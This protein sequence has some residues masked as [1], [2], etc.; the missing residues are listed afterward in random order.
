MNTT[1]TFSRCLT[2][3]ETQLGPQAPKPRSTHAPTV[4]LSRMTG[5]GGTAVAD[6]LAD[7]LQTRRPG[8]PA[9]WTVFHRSLIEKVI[10]DHH[11][12]KDFSR[13]MP[14]NRV[15]YIQ[16]TLEEL[17]GLH[18]SASALVTQIAETILGLAELG[19][20][21]LVGRGAHLVLAKCPSAL[22]VRLVGSLD[23]RTQRVATA[24]SIPADEAR[25]FIK[26]EDAARRRYLR[27][28]F[29]ADIDDPVG[30][31]L[32]VNTD[33]LSAHAVADLIA[34]AVVLRFPE[35]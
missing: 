1:A 21:I 26:T 12:P 16:D 28:H 23:H 33:D 29:D 19:N 3:L 13:F 2:Y 24:Q 7:I 14:E 6:R 25:E 31:D 15:S 17:F 27:T 35:A 8:H 9:P 22:H 5:S 10:A 30:Y 11:L 34:H 18:P 4:T 20:C 32:V